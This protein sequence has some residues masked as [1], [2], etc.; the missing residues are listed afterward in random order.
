MFEKEEFKESAAKFKKLGSLAVTAQDHKNIGS[1]PP[2]EF[3]REL[4]GE[5]NP[6][7]GQ[8]MTEEEISS[9]ISDNKETINRFSKMEPNNFI[10]STLPEL[11][12]ELR[13]GKKYLKSIGK[14]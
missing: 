12:R 5:S 9:W 4:E 3:L 13:L 7:L 6:T 10:R 11:R 1:T 2:K 8:L 14:L